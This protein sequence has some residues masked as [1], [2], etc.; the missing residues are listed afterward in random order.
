MPD[1]KSIRQSIDELDW[2]LPPEPSYYANITEQ[3]WSLRRL[4]VANDLRSHNVDIFGGQE[5][6]ERQVSD[7]SILLGTEFEWVG[8]GR[9]DAKTAGEFAP[10]FYR[11]SKLKLLEWDT[12]WL[13]DTPFDVSKY[14]DAGS[15]RIATAAR[16]R[17]ESD[18]PLTVINTHLDEQSAAQRKLGLSLILHRAKYESIKTHAPVLLTG[19]F[20]SPVT[21]DAYQ[22]L[23]GVKHPVQLNSTFLDRYSWSAKEEKGFEDFKMVDLLGKVEPWQRLSSNY[24]TFTDF[25]APGNT[26]EYSRLDYIMADSHSHWDAASYRVEDNLS[27]NGVYHSDHK[28][29]FATLQL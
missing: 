29:V 1:K 4:Y 24:A 8:V 6:L 9:E 21:D 23:T 14:P 22:V 20:N 26:S 10:I 16:F 28:L 3:P 13:T 5:L 25:L 12:F 2:V 19:D 17:T 18:K 11:K 15:Y 7:L 27:D